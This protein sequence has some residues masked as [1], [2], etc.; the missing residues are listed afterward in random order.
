[1]GALPIVPV[2]P[3][4]CLWTLADGLVGEEACVS[5]GM[6]SLERSKCSYCPTNLLAAAAVVVALGKA[7]SS[8]GLCPATDLHL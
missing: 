1:M 6:K 3:Q 8:G 2:P 5:I 7:P 4:A